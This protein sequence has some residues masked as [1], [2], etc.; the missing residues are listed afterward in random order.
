MDLAQRLNHLEAVRDWQGLVEELERGIASETDAATKAGYHLKLGSILEAKFLQAVKALKH[1]QDAYKLNPALIE[2][3]DQ[4]RSIYWDLGKVNMVQKLLEL[5]LKG[6]QDRPAPATLLIELGD[7]L[8]DAGDYDR[9]SSTYARAAAGED[10]EAHE[11]SERL[12]DVQIDEGAAPER[13]AALVDLAQAEPDPSGRARLYLRAARIGVRWATRHQNTEI[14]AQLL[15][16]ALLHDP[17]NEAAFVFL[18]DL[19][20][21]KEGNWDKVLQLAEKTAKTDGSSPF[22]IAQAGTVAWRQLGNVIRAREWF[23]RLAQV[24]PD[25]PSLQ[26][27]EAQIG[28][29]LGDGAGAPAASPAEAGIDV[30]V[31]VSVDVSDESAEIAVRSSVPEIEVGRAS[32]PEVEVTSRPSVDIEVASRPA[33][34]VSEPA[35]VAVVAAPAPAPAAA[36]PPPAPAAAEPAKPTVSLEKIEELKSKAQKQEQ[37][38]RFNEYVKTLVELAE[39]V[40]DPTEKVD[41]YTKAADLYTTKFSNA[42]EAVKCYEAILAIDGEHAAAIDFLRQSYEKRRDWEKLIGLMKREAGAI[43]EG[44]ARASKFLE[45]AKL[46]TE[47][48][49]KPEVCIDLW[50]EVIANDSENAE[51]L[52]ALAGLHERAKDFSALADVL[53]KQVDITYDTKAKQGLLG[54]LGQLYGERLNNDEAAVE[55]WRQLLTLD[56]ADRKA[57]EALKKLYLKLGRWDDLEVFYAESGKWDEFIRV[58]E[59]QE[60]KETDDG[61]KIGLLMKTADLWLNQ[62]QKADR[63]IKAYEKVLS[64]DAKHLAAAEALIPLYT[65]ANNAKGLAG[66]IEVKLQH[67]QDAETQLALYREVAGL[68]ETKLKEPQKAFERYLS[69]FEIAPG[70]EQSKT[71]VER[72]ARTTG[73]WDSLIAAYTKTIAKAEEEGDVELGISLRL[74]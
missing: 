37:A 45:I 16:E 18:R 8:T 39:A 65:Q 3:L 49:K 13:I 74:G 73:G 33:A 26:A 38:K 31:D 61:A 10:H 12:A 64:I 2:A 29:K 54:K 52:N 60:A 41:Y 58:L 68:Y 5:E 35:P 66:A 63:A 59:T 50:N 7:V 53:Q 4:A 43:P 62:K 46:A 34:P 27:F 30:S 24:A 51:A 72:A 25:H 15:E 42:A 1:F 57:Q 22:M 20:G 28:E 71:D 44:S 69:A 40:E 14:G 11:L 17:T 56:P 21:G 47:R 36:A 67:D 19:W 6:F 23:E 48:V 55:A 32:A 9:A 70:D